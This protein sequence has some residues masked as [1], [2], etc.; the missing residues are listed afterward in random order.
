MSGKKTNAS[1]RTPLKVETAVQVGVVLSPAQE[2]K[3]V[4]ERLVKIDQKML[5]PTFT[6][7]M[8]TEERKRRMMSKAQAIYQSPPLLASLMPWEGLLQP[9]IPLLTPTQGGSWPG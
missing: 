4:L 3:S 1:T 2:A 9:S 8:A 6:V 7:L 5:T